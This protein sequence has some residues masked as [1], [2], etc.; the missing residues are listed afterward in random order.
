MEIGYPKD[1]ENSPITPKFDARE[2]IM[3]RGNEKR[4]DQLFQKNKKFQK[5]FSEKTD[6]VNKVH[7]RKM[8]DKANFDNHGLQEIIG[9]AESIYS[10]QK[11]KIVFM[12]NTCRNLKA[13]SKKRD[14]LGRVCDGIMKASILVLKKGILLNEE[15]I[16]SIRYAKN[17]FEVPEF[18]KFLDQEISKKIL[19]A[20][21]KDNTL[22]YKLLDHFIGRF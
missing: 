22:Y 18:E 14:S 13:F 21:L 19:G 16:Y 7:E 9:K 15:A 2:S 5:D 10:H 4:F 8:E 11:K 6:F 12:V 1:Q 20:L 3:F 17:R